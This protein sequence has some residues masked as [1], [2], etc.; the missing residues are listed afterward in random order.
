MKLYSELISL[1]Y[2]FNFIK[3]P[4]GWELLGRSQTLECTYCTSSA[5]EIIEVYILQWFTNTHTHTHPHAHLPAPHARTRTHTQNTHVRTPTH[6]HALTPIRTH[7][8]IHARAHTNTHTHARAHTDKQVRAPLERTLEKTSG[9]VLLSRS[10]VFLLHTFLG[11][12]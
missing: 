4:P 12:V 8:H 11:Y 9:F 3:C 6:M 7:T 2:F 10:N 1:I 5:C